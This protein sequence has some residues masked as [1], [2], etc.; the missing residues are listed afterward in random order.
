MGSLYTLR[1]IICLDAVFEQQHRRQRTH[2]HMNKHAVSQTTLDEYG[3][4]SSYYN[5]FRERTNLIRIENRLKLICDTLDQFKPP[6]RPNKQ[7]VDFCGDILPDANRH[8]LEHTC[9]PKDHTQT[10]RTSASLRHIR[11]SIKKCPCYL[12]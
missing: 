1:A 3:P 4:H 6:S 7:I 2:T 9:R 5:I 11:K 12:V 8:Y 10:Y